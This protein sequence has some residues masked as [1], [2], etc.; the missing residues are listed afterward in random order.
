M[1]EKILFSEFSRFVILLV[2]VCICEIT[3]A[4]PYAPAAGHAGSTAM[5][6]DDPAF[7]AWATGATVDYTNALAVPDAAFTD[8]SRALGAA[9]SGENAVFDIVSLGRGGEIV[10]DFATPIVDGNGAD[11]AIFE[12]SF[13][14]T[15]LELAY[16]LVSDGSLAP[17][18]SGQKMFLPF[19]SHSLTS[20]PVNA[21][22]TL[23]PTNINGL[24]GKYRGGFGTPFDL[25]DLNA[26]INDIQNVLPSFTFD[27][28]NITQIKIVDVIGDGD[29]LDT[30][31]NPIYDPYATTGSTGFDLDAVGVINQLGGPPPPEPAAKQVPIPFVFHICLLGTLFVSAVPQLAERKIRNVT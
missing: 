1:R 26:L 30:F 20:S 4:G 24:A 7:I 17:G 18:G 31:G 9:S 29:D 19:D 15:F 2:A 11:F 22:G 14:D 27:L 6:H 21:F 16:V 23:D 5:A 13:S 8:A 10:L 25:S 3:N 28:N 12:N